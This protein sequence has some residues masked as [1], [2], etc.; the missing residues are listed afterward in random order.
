MTIGN[1]LNQEL[2]AY[3]SPTI[4]QLIV[5]SNVVSEKQAELLRVQSIQAQMSGLEDKQIELDRMKYS[6]AGLQDELEE[7][8]KASRQRR[9]EFRQLFESTLRGVDYPGLTDVSIDP[10]SLMPKINGQ[11]YDHQGTAFKALATVCYHL[12]MLS[13]ARKADTWFPKFLVIDSPNTGDLNED[14]HAKLLRY[15]SGMQNIQNEKEIN[16]QIILTTRLLIPE[17]QPYVRQE[18]SN[19]NLML[20]RKR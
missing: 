2:S 14:N 15:M 18:I 3:V 1:E 10:Q 16:W 8:K 12:A 20:L 19:P 11:L 4:D 9:E 13:L 5:Q 6:L 7:N 17:L